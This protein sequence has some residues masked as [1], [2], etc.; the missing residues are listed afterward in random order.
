MQLPSGPLLVPSLVP[1][2]SPTCP[3]GHRPTANKYLSGS[4]WEISVFVVF[5]FECLCFVFMFLYMCFDCKC[6][7]LKILGENLK[8]RK[9]D[10]QQNRTTLRKINRNTGYPALEPP[11]I[12]CAIYYS[13]RFVGWISCISVVCFNVFLRVVLFCCSA[14]FCCCVYVFA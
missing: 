6:Q 2:L 10:N 3:T 8:H 12:F 4:S 11:Q 9:K 14:S 1:L 5:F 7:S 13:R